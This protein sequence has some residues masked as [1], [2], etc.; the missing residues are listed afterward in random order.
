[1]TREER[2]K[3]AISK[4]YVY[5]PETGDIVGP[6]GKKIISLDKTGY[7]RIL[8]QENLKRYKI[9]TQ[10]FAWYWVNK[11]IVNSLDHINGVRSDNRIINL[12][13]VTQQENCFNR[14]KAKGYYFNKKAKKWKATITINYKKIHLGYFDTEEEAK[15]AYL[16][17]K[18]KYHII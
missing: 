12:R 3:L 7:Q 11:E 9:L 13:P 6:R 18:A 5:N 14:L 17:A 4:G 1:M 2:C 10:I 16:I 15:Q 8:I